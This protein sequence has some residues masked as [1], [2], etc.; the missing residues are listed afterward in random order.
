LFRA[1]ALL[2]EATGD[3]RD[4]LSRAELAW[5]LKDELVTDDP[6]GAAAVDPGVPVE[7]ANATAGVHKIAVPTPNATANAPTRPTQPESPDVL[8]ALTP[9]VAQALISM[10]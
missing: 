9:L 5:L 6:D 8:I 4:G 3:G 1:V 2:D 10:V 7:S